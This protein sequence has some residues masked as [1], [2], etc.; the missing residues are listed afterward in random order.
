MNTNLRQ[1]ENNKIRPEV[2]EMRFMSAAGVTPRDKMRAGLT[3]SH[4]QFHTTEIKAET[5]LQGFNKIVL[6]RQF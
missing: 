5:M 2:A 6:Q 4:K 3:S 1:T